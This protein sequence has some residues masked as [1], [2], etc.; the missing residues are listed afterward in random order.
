[1][2]GPNRNWNIAVCAIIAIAMTSAICAAQAAPPAGSSGAELFKNN[3][4]VCHGDNGAGSALGKRLLTPDL[5]NKETRQK[6]PSALAQTISAGK[7][8]MPP[9][10]GKLSG[11]E[12]QKLIEYV[13]QFHR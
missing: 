8:N 12:I 10:E 1:M 2:V 7:K 6:S 5:R 11:A 13:R 4:A 3:C 9:F